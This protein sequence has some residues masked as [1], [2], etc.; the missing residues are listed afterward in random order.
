M[1]LAGQT[2]SGDI[3]PSRFV[4]KSGP[5]TVAQATADAVCIGVSQ[6]GSANTPIPGASSLAAT[7]GK[8]IAV[9]S[10]TD[11]CL[12]DAGAAVSDGA[13]LKSDGTGRGIT[14][15]AGDAYYAVAER[16]ADN[17]NEKMQVLLRSGIAE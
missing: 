7:S 11:N 6:Q 10:D 17:A 16:G 9:Y 3:N 13:F 5:Y 14:C 4:V 2:A 15:T 1:P 12:L 8:P